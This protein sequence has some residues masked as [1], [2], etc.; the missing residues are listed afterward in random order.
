[1]KKP[2]TIICLILSAVIILDTLHVWHAVAM[3]YL[4]GEIPGTNRS[5]SPDIMMQVFAL[6]GGFVLA[7]IGNRAVLRTFDRIFVK[8]SHQRA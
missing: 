3:F 2:I 4:A 7:R 1:M 6:T 5:I 8:R